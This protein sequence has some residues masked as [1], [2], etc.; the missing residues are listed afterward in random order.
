MQEDYVIQPNEDETE[1]QDEPA[2][3]ESITDAIDEKTEINRLLD[4]GYIAKQII[5]LGFK[6]R[7][8]YYYAK[9][10]V[11]PEGTPVSPNGQTPQSTLLPAKLDG[12]QVIKRPA[13]YPPASWGVSHSRNDIVASS[14]VIFP[15]RHLQF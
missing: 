4:E 14:C 5:D 2:A 10:R 11:K 8:V 13:G 7:T 3:P 9:K 15:L 12:K 1:I 6:R